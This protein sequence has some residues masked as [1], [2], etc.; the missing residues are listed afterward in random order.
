MGFSSAQQ[1]IFGHDDGYFLRMTFG[2]GNL[3]ARK[4]SREKR[5]AFIAGPPFFYISKI[6]SSRPVPT[7]TTG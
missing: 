5:V 7:D 3:S 4:C 1:T 2:H 6:E